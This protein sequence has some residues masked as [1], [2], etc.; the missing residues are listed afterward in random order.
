MLM[1]GAA[2]LVLALGVGGLLVWRSRVTAPAPLP[3]GQSAATAPTNG[4]TSG[5]ETPVL[6]GQEPALV[7]RGCAERES[8]EACSDATEYSTAVASK[9]AAACLDISEE[10]AR[11][12]CV[13][14]AAEAAGDASQCDRITADPIR[15][16]CVE[17]AVGAS[18]RATGDPAGCQQLGG[19]AATV[20]EGDVFA[21][22]PN[23]ERCDALTGEVGDRC[24]AFFDAA[25]APV[26]PQA[27]TP[28]F[29]GDENGDAD[30]D[31]LTNAREIEL[32]T[33]P[34][35]RD[36]DGDTFSDGEEVKNGYSPLG[37]GRL[38]TTTP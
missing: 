17:R 6:E 14:A 20:C 22:Y 37:P 27:T 2:V 25:V 15:T 4:S 1:I 18:T 19:D 24:R 5:T 28:P 29:E 7:S 32:G 35:D 33:D 30:G 11:D 31:G 16:R 34:T 36:T 12:L 23:R 9:D 3:E 26:H 13:S 38:E 10:L 21:G 8:A